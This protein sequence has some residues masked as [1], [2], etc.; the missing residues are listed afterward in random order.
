MHFH[1]FLFN[2]KYF[3]LNS[4]NLASLIKFYL[5]STNYFLGISI[6]QFEFK[7]YT[8]EELFI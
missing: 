7:Y 6:L 1:K 8:F 5:N 4:N 2:F 3:Y